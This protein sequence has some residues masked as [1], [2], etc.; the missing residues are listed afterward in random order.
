MTLERMRAHFPVTGPL[1]GFIMQSGS[2]TLFGMTELRAIE[3]FDKYYES[4]FHLAKHASK[5]EIEGVYAK[6]SDRIRHSQRDADRGIMRM[7]VSTFLAAIGRNK[8]AP[9]AILGELA[10]N[11]SC[12]VR[13]GVASNEACPQEML[14][15]LSL[16][17]N[18][19]ILCALVLNQSTR[20]EILAELRKS[21]NG[22][23]R[24]AFEERSRKG[25]H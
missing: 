3:I 12:T 6:I 11:P 18:P 5:E 7:S 10:E 20:A 8:N 9:E 15:R 14:A 13:A 2:A 22:F 16:S 4:L 25:G 1:E 24:A 17:D 19:D 21:P 23:I